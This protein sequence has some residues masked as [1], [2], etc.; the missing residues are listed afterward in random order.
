MR[1]MKNRSERRSKGVATR[2]RKKGW[3]NKREN[4]NHVAG[5]L[6]TLFAPVIYA[7][8]VNLQC[9]LNV[10]YLNYGRRDQNTGSRK[11]RYDV[12]LFGANFAFTGNFFVF[13]F[14]F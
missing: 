7:S 9:N 4:S 14:V 3:W 8:A 11:S 2:R 10:D 6:L 1:E 12:L 5:L 13:V